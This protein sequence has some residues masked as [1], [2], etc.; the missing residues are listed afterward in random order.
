M[1]KTLGELTLKEFE[2]YQE[3]VKKKDEI[4]YKKNTVFILF[5]W[6][7]HDNVEHI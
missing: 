6:A 1:I 4:S 7:G 2:E 3:E 5:V